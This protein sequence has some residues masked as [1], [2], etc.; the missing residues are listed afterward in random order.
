MVGR[1]KGGGKGRKGRV[2][3]G[4]G[5]VRPP[6]QRSRSWL[7]VHT[8]SYQRPQ[9]AHGAS[10]CCHTAAACC[11]GL[12]ASCCTARAAQ[13]S[14]RTPELQAN[15]LNTLPSKAARRC[16]V[17]AAQWGVGGGG[18]RGGGWSRGRGGGGGA[19]FA[20]SR[21]HK[22]AWQAQHTINSA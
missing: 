4:G 22:G 7:C 5:V 18:G 14:N 15:G 17:G 20:N 2:R 10:P 9:Q 8:A 13:S 6:I 19:G 11:V 12:K 16:L 3:K 21:T 1:G